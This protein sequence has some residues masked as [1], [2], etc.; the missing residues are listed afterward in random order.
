VD[1]HFSLSTLLEAESPVAFHYNGY[2]DRL[3]T[4]PALRALCSLAPGRL[5]L[6]CGERDRRTFFADLPLADVVEIKC[7]KTAAGWEFDAEA[8]AEAVGGSD[9]FISLNP[10]HSESIDTLLS[11]FGAPQSVGFNRSFSRPL[12]WHPSSH[13]ADQAFEV[14]RQFEPALK[15]EDFSQTIRL[16]DPDVEVARFIRNQVPDTMRVLALHTYTV[17]EKM[18]GAERFIS[19]IDKFLERHPDYVAFILDSV[20]SGLDS[21][22]HGARVF[23][24]PCSEITLARS[25]AILNEADLFLGVDSCM[26]HLADLSRIPGVG[27]F[28]PTNPSVYGF[29]FGPHRHVYSGRAMADLSERDVLSALEE[30]VEVSGTRVSNVRERAR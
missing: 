5:K 4:L 29:R 27:L 21:G 17:P 23:P 18:W 16:P 15:I 10:W 13:A 8:V 22:R 25:F 24:I 9:L 6:V 19:T 1:T 12:R 26:L 2:G 20:R 30:L 28:G 7:R 11:L 14:A 3:L